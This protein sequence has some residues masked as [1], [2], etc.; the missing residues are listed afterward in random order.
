[1]DPGLLRHLGTSP[2]SLYPSTL[3]EFLRR[4][5]ANDV[6]APVRIRRVRLGGGVR[7]GGDKRRRLRPAAGCQEDGLPAGRGS[8][9]PRPAVPPRGVQAADGTRERCQLLRSSEILGGE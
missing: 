6:T 4:D 1:M 7:G 3:R 9:A 2:V 8:D 5:G